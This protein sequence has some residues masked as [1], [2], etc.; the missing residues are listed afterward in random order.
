MWRE[1]N[2]GETPSR[3]DGAGVPLSKMPPPLLAQILCLLIYQTGRRLLT[4][5]VWHMY[6]QV[7]ELG[8]PPSFQ[9]NG[10]HYCWRQQL[11]CVCTL[12]QDLLHF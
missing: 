2:V 7:V 1:A 12:S 9:K 8:P 10:D 11:F 5:C 3:A 6:T 4:F